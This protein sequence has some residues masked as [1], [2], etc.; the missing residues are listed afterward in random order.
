MIPLYIAYKSFLYFVLICA[1]C[2]KD[3]ILVSCK[4]SFGRFGLTRRHILATPTHAFTNGGTAS[5]SP[6]RSTTP[7]VAIEISNATI[8]SYAV[9]DE[10]PASVGSE[11]NLAL[12]TPTFKD[13]ATNFFER[14]SGSGPVLEVKNATIWLGDRVLFDNV[15]FQVSRGEC[16]GIVGN[17]GNGKTSLLDAIYQRLSGIHPQID[18]LSTSMD[19][20]FYGNDTFC[21][22]PNLSTYQLLY[23]MK[24]RGHSLKELRFINIDK[25][26]E[27]DDYS[28]FL[29]HENIFKDG[30]TLNNG[31][32]YMRQNYVTLLDDSMAVKALIDN[33]HR[34]HYARLSIV[35]D[36][37]NNIDKL[38]DMVSL[39][40]STDKFIGT[41]N[42][43]TAASEV[44]KA[45]WARRILTLYND[46]AH[47]V[48]KLDKNVDIMKTTLIDMFGMREVLASRVSELSGGFKMRLYLLYLLLHG[49][50]LLLLDEPTNNL[51]SGTITFLSKTLKRLIETHGHSVLLISHDH[52]FLNTVCSS[53]LQVPG[54]GTLSRYIGNFDNFVEQGSS[55]LQIR[56]TQLQKLTTMLNKL[57]QQY[58]T[59]V[60]ST[61]G[62]DKQRKIIL[63]QKQ[64]LIEETEERI[65]ELKGPD[66]SAYSDIYEKSLLLKS[67][68]INIPK[69]MHLPLVQHGTFIFSDK[70]AFSLRDV[71]LSNKAGE[72]LL[73]NISVD[74]LHC[75]RILLL[76]NNGSGKSTLLAFLNAIAQASEM[77]I[78]DVNTLL[79]PRSY[80]HTRS[81]HWKGDRKTRINYFSQNCSDLLKSQMAVDALAMKFGD[82][83]LSHMQQLMEYL[84]AFHLRDFMNV[85][86]RDLSFGERSR[87]MLALQFLRESTFLFLDEPTN[88]L[89]AY[90]QTMLSALLNKVYTRGGIVMATHDLQLLTSIERI[91]TVL[92]IHEF[93]KVYTFSGDFKDEYIKFKITRPHASRE[94]ID[95]F[96][97]SCAARY[98]HKVRITPLEA[99]QGMESDEAIKRKIKRLKSFGRGSYKPGKPKIKNSKRY[100]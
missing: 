25:I 46:D 1:S 85:N 11:R 70:P 42:S 92:Y 8:P 12:C 60:E 4:R 98:K 86:V 56:E 62:S 54:D 82:L 97:D 10:S 65:Q 96:L 3:I 59:T 72:I 91:T 95:S 67:P 77:G 32:A 20:K 58:K 44:I 100:S 6:T 55:A 7:R 18:I 37:E 40:D 22:V 89:D 81:G 71:M 83:D 45:E 74:I 93:N 16:V 30:N 51:D 63:S 68:S 50:K 14:C 90:M 29:E 88:H 73:S 19:I 79:I 94:E 39:V 33:A 35:Q 23:Y 84:S 99:G 28:Q 57:K 13:R 31:V 5:L 2:A 38:N 47:V 34:V 26:L 49:P 76:G 48:Q 52:S 21:S 27:S 15:G 75:D 41:P 66:K 80:F 36:I 53:I 17:N 61:K 69:L 9:S 64:Q 24:K 78:E 87:L 43:A